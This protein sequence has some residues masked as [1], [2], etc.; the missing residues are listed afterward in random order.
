MASRM[1]LEEEVAKTEDP[2]IRQQFL[3]FIEHQEE[4]KEHKKNGTDRNYL[5]SIPTAAI[6]V[7]TVVLCLFFASFIFMIL[8]WIGSFAQI[9]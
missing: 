6:V 7:L 4:R 2:V 3:D 1:L 9:I 8:R 5:S